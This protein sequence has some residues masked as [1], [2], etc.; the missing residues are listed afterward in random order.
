MALLSIVVPV[1]NVE[2]Y[3]RQCLE[4]IIYSS[5]KDWECV[6]V[7]DGSSDK[8]GAICDEFAEKD[9]RFRVIHQENGG[10]SSARNAGIDVATGKWVVFIDADDFISPSFLFNLI[11]PVLDDNA[12]DIV[13]GG[14]TNYH[15]QEVIGIEQQYEDYLSEDMS[16]ILDH[17][18]GLICSKVL[19]ME[20]LKS[21]TSVRFDGN[22]KIEDMIFMLNYLK[23]VNKAKYISE[24][25][26]YYRRDNP[27]SL[28]KD[29]NR[30]PFDSALSDWRSIYG[31]INEICQKKG[32]VLST[33]KH[34]RI[35]LGNTLWE[36]IRALYRAHLSKTERMFHLN[37]DFSDEEFS[38]L[39][40]C[41]H[42]NLLFVILCKLLL[43]HQLCAFDSL[44][45]LTH[46][47]T[48]IKM[49]LCS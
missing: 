46:N 3:L 44:A 2:D 27:V 9:Q 6:L 30:W 48:K 15:N 10:V 22:A 47:I 12:L 37:S 17:F 19:K 23:Y 21:Q 18:R 5:F 35:I 25:G 24:T 1:Y 20:I 11:A 38:L 41:S 32:I 16:F 8:S 4:S 34:R 13:L 45:S 31:F 42:S 40:Y 33:L 49:G 39:R 26:Y 43:S 14:C 7:D 29:N 28:T 36:V